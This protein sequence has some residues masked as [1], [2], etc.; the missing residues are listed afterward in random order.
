[1]EI[2]RLKK[3]NYDEL[4]GLLDYVFT[5]KNGSS[6]FQK[7]MPKMWARDDEHM[8]KHLAVKE[9]GKLVSVIGIYPLPVDIA[10]E[11]LLFSTVGNIATHPDYE[12]RGYMTM[13]INRAMEELDKMGADASRLGGLRQR[14]N[15]FGY[16]MS[17]RVYSFTLEKQV[18]KKA[19]A[20]KVNGVT[21]TKIARDDLE[22][23]RIAQALHAESKIAVLR[24]SA[25]DYADVYASMVAW[26]NEPWLAKKDG[27]VI[28]Y[29]CTKG[30]AVAENYAYDTDGM[31]AMLAAWQ[32]RIGDTI[33]FRFQPHEVENIRVFSAV[34][35]M[36]VVSPSH[37]KIIHWDKVVGA[38]MRLKASYTAMP[39]GELTLHITGFGGIRL[40]VND[41]GVGCERFDGDCEVTLNALEATRYL[42]GVLPPD[43]TA[44]ANGLASAWLPLPLSWNGQDR[45]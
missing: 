16:E 5:L 45:V 23:L 38:F 36:A 6:D 2:V 15:R 18:V 42:F 44:A 34:C 9:D 4:V 10:G 11:R 39:K 43:S 30:G 32:N 26:Q 22:S 35:N 8:G 13:L 41:V 17:G 28:G 12:G 29:L 25:N 19:W 3:E 7:N 20:D 37:F 31:Q 21:F 14:Y 27:K 40:F 33:S 24:D 1:M